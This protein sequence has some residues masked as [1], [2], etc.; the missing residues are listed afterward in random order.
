MTYTS[1]EI[2]VEAGDKSHPA[3]IYMHILDHIDEKAPTIRTVS[4]ILCNHGMLYWVWY[5]SV[6]RPGHLK[7]RI[8]TASY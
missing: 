8:T 1:E 6:T 5:E 7:E 2:L 3:L 4:V